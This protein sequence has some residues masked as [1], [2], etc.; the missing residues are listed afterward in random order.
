MPVHEMTTL[1]VI[2]LMLIVLKFL[3]VIYIVFVVALI[4]IQTT[5]DLAVLLLDNRRAKLNLS[6]K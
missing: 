2:S 4:S 6:P 5:S 3:H 1:S